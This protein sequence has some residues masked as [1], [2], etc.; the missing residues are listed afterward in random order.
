MFL[1]AA[2][3]DTELDLLIEP[4]SP[5]PFKRKRTTLANRTPVKSKA[6]GSQ[7]ART[8]AVAKAKGSKGARTTAHDDAPIVRTH[9][10]VTSEIPGR[11]DIGV[12]VRMVVGSAVL[13]G[14]DVI[15]TQR[16][17]YT[18]CNLK[19]TPCFD[20]V[21]S[22]VENRKIEWGVGFFFFCVRP[23]SGVRGSIRVRAFEEYSWARH[24]PCIGLAPQTLVHMRI[25][26]CFFQLAR[27][28]S[29]T[30][31]PSQHATIAACSPASLQTH[32]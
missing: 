19:K 10:S 25:L 26:K 31:G 22:C 24:V 14:G 6:K 16:E 32:P 27:D 5:T 29:L 2:K 11:A 21:R 20:H 30:E 9:L 18:I 23:F 7:V 12:S 28:M 8:L 13:S 1:R 15:P 17:E 3:V 4:I